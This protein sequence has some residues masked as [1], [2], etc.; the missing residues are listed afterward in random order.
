MNE[1]VFEREMIDRNAQDC[2]SKLIIYYL[3]DLT[4][5]TA[6]EGILS[7]VHTHNNYSNDDCNLYKLEGTP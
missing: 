6:R 1:A 2:V 3:S 5:N 4:E 7:S